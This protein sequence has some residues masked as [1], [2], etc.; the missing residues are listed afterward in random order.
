MSRS[1]N[2]L[3]IHRRNRRVTRRNAGMRLGLSCGLALCFILF[4][5]SISLAW[6]YSN[7]TEDLPSPEKLRSLLEPSPSK[8]LNPTK[9]YD[10]SGTHLLAELD[11]PLIEQ[12][13]YL[14]SNANLA[15]QQNDDLD[16]QNIPP[17]LILT[18]VAA[19]D[20]GFWNHAGYSLKGLSTQEHPTIAQRLVDDFLLWQEPTS[21]R[22]ALRERLLAAQITSLFGRDKILEWFINYADYGNYTFGAADASKAY[23]NKDAGNLTLTEAA[24]LAATAETPLLNPWD[25]AVIASDRGKQTIQLMLAKG[26]ISPEQAA[27]ANLETF[28][29]DKPLITAN[30]FAPDFVD[31]TLS[32]LIGRIQLDRVKRGGFIIITTLDYNLQAQTECALAA[33]INQLHGEVESPVAF[34]G[35]E[36]LAARLLPTLVSEKVDADRSISAGILVLNPQKGEILV[37]TSAGDK[38]STNWFPGA[39]TSNTTWQKHPTGTVLTPMVYLTAFT[40]GFTLASLVWDIPPQDPLVIPNT[41]D[42]YQGAMRL[43]IALAN[44]YLAPA[45]DIMEQIGVGNVKTISKQF[46]IPF[47][48]TVK[49]DS[50]SDILFNTKATLLEISQIYTAIANQ[51]NQLGWLDNNSGENQN[52]LSVKSIAILSVEDDLGNIWIDNEDESEEKT[53]TTPQLAYLLTN[54]LSDKASAWQ[55][56]GHPNVL[57]VGFQAAAKQGKTYSQDSSAWTVGYTSELVVSIWTGEE[58]PSLGVSSPQVSSSLWRAIMQYASKSYPPSSWESPSGISSLLVCD[59]S[60]MLPSNNCPDSVEEVF[61]AGTEPTAPDTLFRI[62]EVNKETGLLATIFTPAEYIENK[63]FIDFPAEAMSWAASSGLDV[64][65]T[66]YDVISPDNPPN[67]NA[68]ITSPRIFSYVSG[69][70]DIKGTAKGDG[71]QYYRLQVGKGVNPAQWLQIGDDFTTPV[72]DGS[73]IEW[74]TSN[75]DG[76]YA[77]QLT[78]I[79]NENRIE[80]TFTQVTVDNRPPELSIIYPQDGKNISLSDSGKLT[81][82]LN[83]N[84]NLGIHQVEIFIDKKSIATLYQ[85]PFAFSWVAKKGEHNLLVKATDIA[86]NTTE[87]HITFSITP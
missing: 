66:S 13:V 6:A 4:L 56:L 71:F 45:L 41:N 84:D 17:I 1:Q 77:I 30:S 15:N 87:T 57:E 10:R 8:L 78:V 46:G 47:D 19:S 14:T 18:T 35:E 50:A 63:V 54:A 76:L 28:L 23:F 85:S 58:M 44:D 33:Q 72:S 59:P 86:G 55:T 69:L 37:M 52:S 75:L 61:I 79:Q 31:Y 22:K 48:T 40:R 26:W 43:R 83:V 73:L 53:V 65:P 34:N 49:E 62:L 42:Q 29:F 38:D 51:G 7:I 24:I 3:H 21:L 74:D 25:A 11:N 68:T 20:P 5:T 12:N 16:F 64:P 67:S 80:N 32:Q 39:Y 27:Q 60:G 9:I 81:I 82:Q 36:C 70:V 2:L